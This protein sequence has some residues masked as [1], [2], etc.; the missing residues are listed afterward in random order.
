MSVYLT[1][2]QVSE[3]LTVPVGTLYQWRSRGHGPRAAKVGRH[4]RWKQ[5]D[6]DRWVDDQA[7]GDDKP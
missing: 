5:A 4:L 1:T 2:E 7:T 3:Y 6:V